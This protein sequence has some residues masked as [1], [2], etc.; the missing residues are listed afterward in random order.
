VET[1]SVEG[2]AVVALV[3]RD[4]LSGV[5]TAIHRSGHG[6]NARVLDAARGEVKGQLRRAGVTTEVDLDLS[7]AENVV[8]LI[9]APGRTAK[10]A[11]ML[12]RAGVLAVRVVNRAGAEVPRPFVMPVPASKP[13]STIPSVEVS[14]D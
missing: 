12:Q 11:E 5:L 13:R 1:V 14:T 10:T 8:I 6:H 9:H 2:D 4:Q 3:T 7:G